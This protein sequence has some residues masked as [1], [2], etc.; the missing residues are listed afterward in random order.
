MCMIPAQIQILNDVDEEHEIERNVT[1]P[2]Q[3]LHRQLTRKRM[4]SIQHQNDL[5]NHRKF[6]TTKK[7]VL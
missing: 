1:I 4:E 5:P 2:I 3:V 6:P 7:L